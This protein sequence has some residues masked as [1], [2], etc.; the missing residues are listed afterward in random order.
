MALFWG[1]VRPRP[2]LD[3]GQFRP[4]PSS[5]CRKTPAAPGYLG[6]ALHPGA[7]GVLEVHSLLLTVPIG[8]S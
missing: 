2:H 4:G 6:L 7:A 3:I 8:A 1:F 5:H